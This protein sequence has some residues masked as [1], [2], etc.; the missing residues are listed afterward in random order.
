MPAREL[1]CKVVENIWLTPTVMRVRFEPS[2]AFSFEP[3]QFISVVVP[4]LD[5][6]GRPLR[7][8][9]SLASPQELAKKKG[10]DLMIKLVEGGPG[11]GYM[12]SLRAGDE[13]R[14]FAP[15]GDFVYRPNPG[16]AVCFVSTGTGLA[17]FCAIVRSRE[18]QENLPSRALS[19]FGARTEDEIL[20][21]KLFE[22][23]GVKVVNA[24]SRPSSGWDAGFRG[25]VTDYL[26]SLPVDWRWQSTDFY[27]CGNGEMV[28]EVRRILRDGRGVPESAIHQEVYFASSAPGSSPVRKAA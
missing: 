9:Y 16:R 20:C 22:L 3:G 1:K 17:P 25:R 18:F 23:S 7:R 26:R 19:V 8:A 28:S 27:L 4:V 11:S 5:S 21:Q 6:R 10:Y 12:K 2:R 14:L 13:L 24:I 15:Y